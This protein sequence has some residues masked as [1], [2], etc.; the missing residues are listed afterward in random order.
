MMLSK[1]RLEAFSDGVIAIII[2]IM[3]L[4]IPL[5]ETTD[6]EG[7]LAFLGSIFI[8]FISFVIVGS[9]WNQHHKA[10]AYVEEVTNTVIWVNLLYL[11]FLSLIPI[12]T[13]WVLQYPDEIVPV[14]CYDIVYLL[15][16]ISYV[17]IFKY[18]IKT[19]NHKSVRAMRRLRRFKSQK[20]KPLT[21]QELDPLRRFAVTAIIIVGVIT[22]ALFQTHF[23]TEILIALPVISSVTNLLFDN[24]D[25][26][27]KRKKRKKL[28]QQRQNNWKSGVT[29]VR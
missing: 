15:V 27:K 10:F 29:R 28:A 13:N 6:L 4:S 3:V 5:P 19:S 23:Y 17:I 8:Y 16:N 14:I 18:I 7:I 11:F 26:F 20:P 2:T 25:S 24:N 1:Q 9:F 21:K 12:L 22:Y